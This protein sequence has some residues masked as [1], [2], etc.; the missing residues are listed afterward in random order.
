[1]S[2]SKLVV[3]SASPH[4]PPLLSAPPLSSL[5]LEDRRPVRPS[6]QLPGQAQLPGPGH[7]QPETPPVLGDRDGGA[8]VARLLGGLPSGSQHPPAG[9][10]QYQQ[11][12]RQ[13]Q[14]R[15]RQQ[16]PQQEPSACQ[17]VAAPGSPGCRGPGVGLGG[18]GLQRLRW[19]A[20]GS[21]VRALA[22]ACFSSSTCSRARSPGLQ[23]RLGQKEGDRQQ[24]ALKMPSTG[25]RSLGRGSGRAH[26]AGW[27]PSHRPKPV[28][29]SV[30]RKQCRRRAP[31]RA[32]APDGS[33]VHQFP[34]LASLSASTMTGSPP[35]RQSRPP[36]PPAQPQASVSCPRM[37]SLLQEAAWPWPGARQGGLV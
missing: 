11:C 7:G 27:L 35:E 33:P 31:R 28:A 9:S 30:W 8:G 13:R 16:P 1:M 23:D 14:R 19:P 25:G 26:C 6:G 17:V 20:G 15:P 24:H 22:G 10:C 18:P 34:G 32:S 5:P 3:L 4:P 21:G 29:T 36:L 2:L 37:L 12:Q